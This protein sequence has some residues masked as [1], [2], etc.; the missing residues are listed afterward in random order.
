MNPAEEKE[1][2]IDTPEGLKE[3]SQFIEDIYR[4]FIVAL[5]QTHGVEVLVG[6]DLVKVEVARTKAGELV[7]H[8]TKILEFGG[9]LYEE[10]IAELQ[11][12]YDTIASAYDRLVR[13]THA[14]ASNEEAYETLVDTSGL[15]ATLDRAKLLAVHADEVVY[16]YSELETVKITT[17][18]LK[19]GKLLFEQLKIAA[20]QALDKV[21]EIEQFTVLASPQDL[22]QIAARLDSEL[23]AITATL[24]QLQKS[25]LR[26]FETDTFAKETPE[27]KNAREKS[28]KDER[29]AKLFD[30]QTIFSEPLKELLKESRNRTILQERHSSPAAFEATLKREVFR[31]EAP[32][33]LD[34]L[35]GIKH[36]SAFLF[37]KDM[38]LAEID[39]FDSQPKREV[40]RTILQEKNIPY[41]TYTAWIQALPYL[42]STVATHDDMTFMEL[43]I[44]SEIEM[45]SEELEARR[46]SQGVHNK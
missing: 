11:T 9:E 40:I 29:A 42:E 10:D 34:A 6:G 43:F 45:L 33:K 27:R 44:R 18:E 37:L 21:T 15:D 30:Q 17:A 22:L 8:H 39:V 32:S 3:F 25:L 24:E 5:Q 13:S 7:L 26:Y 23:D 36:E 14:V 16:E 1:L 41:E 35:L 20:K 19:L 38:S 4:D 46:N 28:K 2:S 12:L 31:V